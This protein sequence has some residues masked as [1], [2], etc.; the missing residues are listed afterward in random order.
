MN[1]TYTAGLPVYWATCAS[2]AWKEQMP[3]RC[4]VH[5]QCLCPQQ[6][7]LTRD[8]HRKRE[9]GLRAEAAEKLEE[10]FRAFAGAQDPLLLLDYDGTLAPF[11]LDRFQARPW[12]GVRELLTRIQKQ[13]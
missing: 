1:T 2:C 9:K 7:L 4:A 5:R 8:W 13:G 12:T 11:R 6:M 3:P 10:F